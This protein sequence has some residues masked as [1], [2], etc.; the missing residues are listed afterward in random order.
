MNSFDDLPTY[1]PET[2]AKLLAAC[3]AEDQLRHE[4]ME[5]FL[6]ATHLVGYATNGHLLVR[7]PLQERPG[8][9]TFHGEE[10]WGGW[11]FRF[12]DLLDPDTEGVSLGLGPL[13]ETLT[14]L[15]TEPRI[16]TDL[17]PKCGHVVSE[18]TVGQKYEQGAV[19]SWAGTTYD[20]EK[21]TTAVLGAARAEGH[22]PA[23]DVTVTVYPQPEVQASETP[24]SPLIVD[25]GEIRVA[26]MP[27]FIP[28]GDDESDVYR[29]GGES[30]VL[31][32]KEEPA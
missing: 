2:P 21:L 25:V 32:R 26:V 29:V 13:W 17:C 30:G 9:M 22:E 14:T 24:D 18:E 15:P 6:D 27:M 1:V 16:E 12:E 20:P 5:P 31:G 8:S 28:D 23:E 19:V 10:E 11:Q 7:A 3:T 4:M